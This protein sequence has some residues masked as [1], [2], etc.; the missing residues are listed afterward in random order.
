VLKASFFSRVTHPICPFL[1]AK[2]DE[3]PLRSLA[4]VIVE[5]LSNPSWA[6]S[7]SV[8]SAEAIVISCTGLIVIVSSP[9]RSV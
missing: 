7:S 1:S 9:F 3:Q 2:Y 6:P 8:T 4:A 5:G